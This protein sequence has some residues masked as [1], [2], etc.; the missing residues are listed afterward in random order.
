MDDIV[1]RIS[2]EL[3]DKDKLALTMMS[4]RFDKLKHKMLFDKIIHV[5]KIAQLSY[6]NNFTRVEIDVENKLLPK[7]VKCIYFVASSDI[8]PWGV[9]HLMFAG[10]FNEPINKPIPESVTHLKF[11]FNFD[12]PIKD[13]IPNSVT[14]LTFGFNFDQPIKDIIPN[15]VTRLT[16]GYMFNKSIQNGIPSSV[17]HLKFGYWFRQS[18]T[19]YIPSSTT[20]IILHPRYR[21][22]K[23]I[24]LKAKFEEQK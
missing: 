6:F 23:N 22:Y 5:N 24:T 3:E 15:S 9:T 14:H 19:D 18:L 12:Q 11:G 13:I 21:K 10:W 17:T 2:A 20:E 8:I 16:F 7:K 4:K 1:I